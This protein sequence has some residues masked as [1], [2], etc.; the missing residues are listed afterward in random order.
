MQEDKSFIF[1]FHADTSKIPQEITHISLDGFYHKSYTLDDALI[2]KG[3]ITLIEGDYFSSS[4]IKK[5]EDIPVIVTDGFSFKLGDKI[6]I[7]LGNRNQHYLTPDSFPQTITAYVK[8]ICTNDNYLPMLQTENFMSGL[9]YPKAADIIYL[10]DLSQIYPIKN[11]YPNKPTSTSNPP[12]YAI[13]TDYAKYQSTLIPIIEKYGIL[14]SY[15]NGDILDKKD[16]ALT[17]LIEN[18]LPEHKL[19]LY[20]AYGVEAV[21]CIF[22]I[23]NMLMFLKRWR[24]NG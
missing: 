4:E 19:I 11:L 2:D 17:Y 21:L 3:F 7:T 12:V 5:G 23:L 15:P 14:N 1:S 6:R 8:G 20:S 16:I 24:D 18:E 9:Q 10:P 22:F 13:F